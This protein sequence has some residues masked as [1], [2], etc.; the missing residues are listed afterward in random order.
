MWA[1]ELGDEIRLIGGGRYS[2]PSCSGTGSYVVDLSGEEEIC[3]CPDKVRPCK[4]LVAGTIFRARRRAD[5]RR[6]REGATG[7]CEGCGGRGDLIE[8]GQDGMHSPGT[9][10]CTSCADH[11]GVER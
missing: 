2:V 11:M 8:D 5:M 3:E 9:L 10:L 4:H 1:S 6:A 7:A